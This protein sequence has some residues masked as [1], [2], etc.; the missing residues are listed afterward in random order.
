MSLEVTLIIKA[1][2]WVDDESITGASNTADTDYAFGIVG[3]LDPDTPAFVPTGLW[4][5]NNGDGTF[6]LF[7]A[8]EGPDA[9]SLPSENDLEG[10]TFTVSEVPVLTLG[11]AD[12]FVQEN[13]LGSPDDADFASVWSWTGLTND[14]ENGLPMEDSSFYTAVLQLAQAEEFNCECEEETENE[15]LA[16][17]RRRLLIRLGY[18]AQA[19]NPP[20]GMADL[21]NDFLLQSQRFLYRK[22]D[23]LRTER[24]FT[25]TMEQGVRFYDLPDNDETCTKQLDPYKLTWVGVEDV[26]GAWY[27]LSKGIPPEWY[28]SVNFQG[29]P[30]RYEIRQCIEV[31][32]APS[33]EGYKLR[34]KGHFGLTSF[35][36]DDDKTTIDSELVFLW[37]LANAKAHYGQPDATNYANQAT[38][39]LGALVSGAHQTARYVPGTRPAQP[40]TPP[41][42]LPLIG[43]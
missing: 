33:A 13:Q 7:L 30:V 16:Q 25:W 22:Y 40:W 15:T 43:E 41:V 24:F 6:D 36:E 14:A 23:A 2:D 18:S 10:L 20:P 35:T 39:Y 21:L 38:A 3:G 42:F 26:N 4:T 32:P 11:S 29:L 31:F 19:D 17:L 8:A 12:N 28:T 9:D 37:A 1:E 27:N 34:I 5:V